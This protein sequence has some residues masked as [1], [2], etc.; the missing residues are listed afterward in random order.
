MIYEV[1]I[2]DTVIPPILFL[3]K[4]VLAIQGPLPFHINFIIV[5]SMSIKK[6]LAGILI[7]IA[8]RLQI[9][10]WG[11]FTS[12]L[13]LVFKS[14]SMMCLHLFR[15]SLIFFISVFYFQ[16]TSPEHVFRRLYLSISFFG[17]L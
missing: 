11:K 6:N 4:I 1:F 7:A 9:S 10:V 15:S 8:L 12:L 2:S 3:L 17:L 5:L 13:C 14:M 16:D